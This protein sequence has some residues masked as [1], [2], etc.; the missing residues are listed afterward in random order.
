LATVDA[1]LFGPVRATP[2]VTPTMVANAMAG[3]PTK[4]VLPTAT[5]SVFQYG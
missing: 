3:M 2:S 4:N 5:A 1:A